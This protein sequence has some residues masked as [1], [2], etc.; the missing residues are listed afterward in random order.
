MPNEL[1]GRRIAFLTATEGV[2][3]AEL[4]SPWQAV[5]E[6][7][8]TPELLAPEAGKVQAFNHL[9]RA[10]TFEVT[11]TI[12]DADPAQY[13]GLVLP[14]GVANAD[15]LR[16]VPEAVGFATAMFA[17]GKPAAVICHAPWLLVEADLV[18]GRTMTSWPSLATDLRNAGATWV[19]TEVQVCTAGLNTLVT[20]RKPDDLPAFCDAL[21]AQFRQAAPPA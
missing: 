12:A 7:G 2:E 10:D 15:F 8:G 17:A 1:T 16:T 5:L 21:V 6:A 9:D 19:D 13:A 4:T 14:G 11:G 3:Q 18:R 20:S